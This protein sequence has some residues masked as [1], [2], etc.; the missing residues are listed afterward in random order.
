YN[1]TIFADSSVAPSGGGVFFK[2]GGHHNV[3]FF[4]NIFYSRN[5]APMVVATDTTMGVSFHNNAYFSEHDRYTFVWGDDRYTSLHDFKEAPR[6]ETM[7]GAPTGIVADPHLLAPGTAGPLGY[8]LD[9]KTLRDRYSLQ[10][11]SPLIRQGIAVS[12]P[13]PFAPASL[14]ILGNPIHPTDIPD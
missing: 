11:K 7:N 13:S 4:N 1:N 10:K 14:D 12:L 8:P 6:Q 3:R 2:S 5:G 9:L